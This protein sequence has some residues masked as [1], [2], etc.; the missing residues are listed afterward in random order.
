MQTVSATWA[1]LAANGDFVLQTK[2]VIN[3]ADYTDI[4]APVIE[5]GLMQNGLSVGNVCSAM[6]RFSMLTDDAIPRAAEVVIQMRLKNGAT[7]SEWLPAGTFYISRR[8]KDPVTGLITLTCYDALLRANAAYTASGDY[9]K[10]MSA[11][12]GEIAAA[13][14]VEIDARTQ[15]QS[16]EGWTVPLPDAFADMRSMLSGIAAAH[17]ANWIMTPENKLRMVKIDGAGDLVNVAGVVGRVGAGSV[18]TVTGLRVRGP[19]GYI[20]Y[21]NT[22]G[23]VIQI[24]A[25]HVSD[26]NTEYLTGRLLGMAYQP[27]TLEGAI[28]DPAAELGDQIINRD[29]IS[30]VICI[31]RLTLNVAF[32]ASVSAPEGEE[33][34]DEYPYIGTT[35]ELKEQVQRI[36][37]VVANKASVDDLD[38]LRATIQDLSVEA[39][40]AGIIYSA[41]YSSEPAAYVY[42]ATNV[43]PGTG[44]YP[45][46]GEMVTKGFA[47]DFRTGQIYGAFY[48]DQIAALDARVTAL[49]NR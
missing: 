35:E 37:S 14:N 21:G 25:E 12:A 13:L 30:S 42:P 41:D 23:L 18:R 19:D 2:A 36:T 34:D 43:Y 7:E 27:Y 8:E 46:A 40:R 47:I 9:P 29:S 3:G 26:L 17:G 10:A 48:S 15:F 44:I 31:E 1:A 16:G 6:M 33:A 49:E 28:Y 39:L 24:N 45:S 5:R 20:V 4:S 32:R 11:V 22:D 38:A